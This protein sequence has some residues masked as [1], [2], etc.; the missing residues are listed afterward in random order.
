M[1]IA[2]RIEA[3]AMTTMEATKMPAGLLRKSAAPLR[4]R[5]RKMGL[6]VVCTP[7]SA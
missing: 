2:T 7:M 1:P 4:P 5:M 6:T 3:M